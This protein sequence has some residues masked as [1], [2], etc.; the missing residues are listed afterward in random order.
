APRQGNRIMRFSPF[1]TYPTRDG[2]IALGAATNDEWLAVLRAIDRM[3]L[4]QSEEWMNMGWRV[5][6]NA[7]VDAIVTAWTKLRTT[8][9]AIDLLNSNDVA[10][11]PIRA[12]SDIMAWEHLAARDMLKPL[13][14]PSETLTK[15]VIAAG[16]PIKMGRTH[17][18]YVAPAPT[19]GQN[20]N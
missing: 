1:N 13:E 2:A 11:S 20:N 18:G 15:R 14:H 3:D 4:A 9:E 7:E 12:I 17:K 19:L 6:H 5:S 16:F 8:A 10:S